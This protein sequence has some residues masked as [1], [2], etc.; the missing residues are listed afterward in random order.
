[1]TGQSGI[2]SAGSKKGDAHNCLLQKRFPTHP[3]PPSSAFIAHPISLCCGHHCI[4]WTFLPAVGESGGE[5]KEAL[6]SQASR[7][8]VVTRK[9]LLFCFTKGG[10]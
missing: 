5:A 9:K 8:I 7:I 6:A 1:M 3:P 4:G 10:E 2:N